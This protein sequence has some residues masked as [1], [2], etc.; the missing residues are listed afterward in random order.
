[1]AIDRGPW[2]ALVDDDGSNLVGSIWNKA[3]I[4]T[5]VLDPVDAAILAPVSGAWTPTDASGAGLAFGTAT[6]RYW[7]LDK[8]VVVQ[9][10]VIYPTTANT[11]QA[12]IAGLPAANGA[13]YGGLYKCDNLAFGLL[14]APGSA[15]VLV[16]HPTSGL[17]VTNATLS[18]AQLIFSGVY[19]IA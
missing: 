12:T 17:Q 8:L 10:R 16:V 5:V 6:G 9:G 7:R 15:S 13:A 3:A 19:L 4:K 2:N 14:I 1:M 11:A 18:G